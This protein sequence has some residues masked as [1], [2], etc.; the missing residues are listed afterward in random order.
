M[1]LHTAV[2][3]TEVQE[4]VEQLMQPVRSQLESY[5]VVLGHR[6]IRNG[7]NHTEAMYR[8]IIVY[9]FAS[10]KPS[11]RLRSVNGTPQNGCH[12]SGCKVLDRNNCLVLTITHPQVFLF[13]AGIGASMYA[14]GSRAMCC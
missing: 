5:H 2:Q 12:F 8:S 11:G 4:R 7:Y 3:E 9:P 10:N 14:S 6:Q 13:H 1:L